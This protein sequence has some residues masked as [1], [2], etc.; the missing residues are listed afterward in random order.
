MSET[1]PGGL[2]KSADGSYH[3]ANGKPVKVTPAVRAAAKKAGIT[4]SAAKP[5]VE[6]NPPKPPAEPDSG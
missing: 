6:E 2:Y 1:I 4:L 3:D 5:A